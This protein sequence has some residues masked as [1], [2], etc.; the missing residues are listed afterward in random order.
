MQEPHCMAIECPEHNVFNSPVWPVEK[1][2]GLG[3]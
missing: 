2:D 3:E 1:P